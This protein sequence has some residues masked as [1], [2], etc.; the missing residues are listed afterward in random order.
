[1]LCRTNGYGIVE[2]NRWITWYITIPELNKHFQYT[3]KLW[4]SMWCHT[5]HHTIFFQYGVGRWKFK[6]SPES[7]KWKCSYYYEM[8]NTGVRVLLCLVWIR[9]V[10]RPIES[11]SWAPD[12]VVFEIKLITSR[13]KSIISPL[14][15]P[16]ALLCVSV[17]YLD[18]GASRKRQCRRILMSVGTTV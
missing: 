4:N 14:W 16:Q 7:K 9:A 6:F 5:P 11:C 2:S 17:L 15:I 10:D 12:H 3:K 18:D 13:N 8:V 1:M